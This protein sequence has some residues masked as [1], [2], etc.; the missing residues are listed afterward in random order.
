MKTMT[1]TEARVN[2]CGLVQLVAGPQ[3]ATSESNSER[4]QVVPKAFSHMIFCHFS[5]TIKSR[6]LCTQRYGILLPVLV[7]IYLIVMKLALR[8]LRVPSLVQSIFVP[9]LS[10]SPVE[11]TRHEARCHRPPLRHLRRVQSPHCGTF[12]LYYASKLASNPFVAMISGGD[13]VQKPRDRTDSTH[14][15]DI[16]LAKRRRKQVACFTCEKKPS[17]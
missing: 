12:I 7:W 5:L 15:E 11:P 4:P 13:G 3:N 2:F 1:I 9:V 17:C 14:R 10:R 16:W 6:I 8:N